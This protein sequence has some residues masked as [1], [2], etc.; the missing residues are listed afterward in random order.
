MG[1]MSEHTR[2]KSNEHK[3]KHLFSGKIHFFEV[4]SGSGEKYPVSVKVNCDCAYMGKQGIANDKMCS[5]ILAVLK[6]IINSAE[7][8]HNEKGGDIAANRTQS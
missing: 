5:H 2:R 4:E 7:I 8:N 6:F 1:G 3:V